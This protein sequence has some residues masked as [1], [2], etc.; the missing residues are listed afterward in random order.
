M[1]ELPPWSSDLK[2][3]EWTIQQLDDEDDEAERVFMTEIA[4][5][6]GG[7]PKPRLMRAHELLEPEGLTDLLQEPKRRPGRP[8]DLLPNIVDEFVLQDVER[9]RALWRRHYGK[10]NR[11]RDQIS[12][13]S[14][15]AER[16]LR[17]CHGQADAEKARELVD[18]IIE[19]RKRSRKSPH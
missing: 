11:R 14:I 8:R 6:L 3:K 19:R 17:L 1:S 4:P 15:A 10:Q 5:H 7:I 13:E 16:H 18:E 2:L 12:A 9:I